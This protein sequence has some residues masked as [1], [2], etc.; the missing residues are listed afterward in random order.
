MDK[1]FQN[2]ALEACQKFRLMVSGSMALPE[3]VFKKWKVSCMNGLL[4]V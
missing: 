2:S 1:G 3:S 4:I